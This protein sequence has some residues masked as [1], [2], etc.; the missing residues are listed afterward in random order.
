ME[1][2]G[3]VRRRGGYTARMHV[4]LTH[5]FGKVE[6]PPQPAVARVGFGVHGVLATG[7]VE[8]SRIDDDAADAGA[9]SAGPLGEGVDDDVRAVIQRFAQ[10][11]RREGVVDDEGYPRLAGD[12]RQFLERRDL[13]RGIRHGLAEDRAR[14]VVDRGFD[15]ADVRDVDELGRDAY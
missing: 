12:G 11:G 8:P 3:E 1:E 9:V 7:P 13:E 2:D 10:I 4:E 15:G 6:T 5:R 14:F